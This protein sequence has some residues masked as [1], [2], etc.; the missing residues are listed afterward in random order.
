MMDHPLSTALDFE[1]L[2]KKIS[3][4]E[5]MLAKEVSSSPSSPTPSKGK[6]TKFQKKYTKHMAQL[7]RMV[8]RAAT[9]SPAVMNVLIEHKLGER[10]STSSSTSPSGVME[11]SLH[12]D[13]ESIL[14]DDITEVNN[15]STRK[16]KKKDKEDKGKNNRN[17]RISESS[18][19]CSTTVHSDSTPD[20]QDNKDDHKDDDLPAG[21]SPVIK[22]VKPV[23]K[24]PM[25][26][27]PTPGGPKSQRI[28]RLCAIFESPSAL[29]HSSPK[30][31][32]DEKQQKQ[33]Q[34][35]EQEG[36]QEET[37]A[38]PH[39][40]SSTSF[41]S[42]KFPGVGALRS[43]FA[44]PVARQ[45]NIDT[46]LQSEQN[47][48]V[49]NSASGLHA[50]PK[51]EAQ[52]PESEGLGEE[53]T[54]PQL[55]SV[56]PTIPA[57]LQ[58]M[59]LLRSLY[60]SQTS[61]DS[62]SRNPYD[63]TCVIPFVPI[64]NEQGTET[65]TEE[66][67]KKTTDK[68]AD[69]LT[70]AEAEDVV[71]QSADMCTP[72]LPVQ[73]INQYTHVQL[74]SDEGIKLYQAVMTPSVH[75]IGS[76]VV[77]LVSLFPSTMNEFLPEERRVV[78]I[79]QSLGIHPIYINGL[80]PKETLRRNELFEISGKWSVYPQLFVRKKDTG[81]LEFFADVDQIE[82]LNDCNVLKETLDAT[83]H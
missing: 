77:A 34:E 78:L 15:E 55:D 32:E 37:I 62:P 57:K 42:S 16:Q 26:P 74:V 76:R 7:G 4:C 69:L 65:T 71:G 13:D 1:G 36:E 3:K 56:A 50:V 48:T 72:N 21:I 80:D 46:K 75:D 82:A 39:P 5:R 73:I 18:S 23:E 33:Q 67:T 47:T 58:G 59:K 35:D 70:K 27:L 54:N 2:I 43:V 29:R 11:M 6:K 79:F 45:A 41:P 24:Q 60:K 61:P 68:E 52:A 12:F 64:R 31:E 63:T 10:I 20:K 66:G 22:V 30:E 49:L 83:I 40:I 51:Q 53:T 81:K 19:S 38:D 8:Y 14:D 28:N 17:K 9:D 25:S 44:S